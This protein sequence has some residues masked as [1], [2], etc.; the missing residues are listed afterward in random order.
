LSAESDAML[1]LALTPGI[2]PRTTARLLASFGTAAAVLGA[3][4]K[5][6]REGA[7]VATELRSAALAARNE[8]PR[9]REECARRGMSV[10]TLDSAAYPLPLATIYDPPTALFLRGVAPGPGAFARSVA[11]IGTRRPSEQGLSFA[12]RLAADL[13][14]AG[15]V[16][17]SGLAL[18]IDAEAHRA[19]VRLGGTGI[20]VLPG[21]LDRVHPQ[22]HGRLAA[23]LC[24]NGCL[25]SEHPPGTSIRRGSFVGRN[26]LISGLAR[27]VAVIEAPERSGALL[28]A[29]FGLEQGRSVYAMPGRPGDERIAG[30]LRLL[31]DG[32][33][34]L[35][36]AADLLL[37]LGLQAAVDDQRRLP[38]LGSAERALASGSASF[39]ALLADSGLTP[40]ELLARLG[41]LELE[42]RVR[43]AADGRY[44]L[45]DG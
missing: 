17:V 43:R 18:G 22:F 8:V 9:V 33:G 11:I 6:W 20:A 35:L 32:A 28:T 41:R 40:P 38:E 12:Y 21:G 37:E 2:G 14:R 42:G 25:L 44:Y 15:A 39:D 29:D 10:V 36:S 26:R 24:E 3:S 31:H 16:V 13:S 23:A 4:A 30:N 45:Q 1:T 27:V 5:G 34:L 7:G 19:V